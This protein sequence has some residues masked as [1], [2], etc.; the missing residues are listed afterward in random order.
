MCLQNKQ[1]E[2]WVPLIADDFH[3]LSLFPSNLRLSF[4]PHFRLKN[5]LNLEKQNCVTKLTSLTISED[6]ASDCF[7]DCRLYNHPQIN[8]ICG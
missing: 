5:Y 3:R 8:G 1:A 6:A 7:T 4:S 2:H